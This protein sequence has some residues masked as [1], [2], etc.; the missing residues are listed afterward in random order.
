MKLLVGALKIEKT[1]LVGAFSKYCVFI[2]VSMSKLKNPCQQW[3]RWSSSSVCPPSSVPCRSS[4]DSETS[5]GL[6][7]TSCGRWCGSWA[8]GRGSW[9]TAPRARRPPAGTNSSPTTA[10]GTRTRARASSASLTASC[11]KN[12][13]Q[14]LCVLSRYPRYGGFSV[15]PIIEAVV[16]N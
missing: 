8:A 14:L 1:L 12:V 2:T 9:T 5:S 3:P 16:P 4:A 11:V 15:F 10:A 6:L 7:R 13:S